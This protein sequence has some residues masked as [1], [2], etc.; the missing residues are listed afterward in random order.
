MSANAPGLKLR[1]LFVI[2]PEKYRDEEL[3]HPR[4]TLKKNNV[5]VMVVSTR[6]GNLQ[7][8]LGHVENVDKSLAD[9][10]GENFDAVIV[11]GGA[12][13]P[14]HL[15]DNATLREILRR[16]H[17]MGK[18]VAGICLGCVVV[19][20]AGLLRGVEATVYKSP[21]STKILREHGAI[22]KNCPVVVSGFLI[23]GAGPAAAREFGL[24][25]VKAIESK[26]V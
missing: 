10:A 15:W 17:E 22:Y 4:R 18:V 21:E 23:T 12:G 9:V 2:S 13:A 25:I 5:D 14:T 26:N 8:M 6:K 1:A 19:A 3:N 11:V 16:H 7:G 20:K 24:A